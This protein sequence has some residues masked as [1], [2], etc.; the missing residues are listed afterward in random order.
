M[1]QVDV[2]RKSQQLKENGHN[3][4]QAAL[5]AFS[6]LIDIPESELFAISEGFGGGIGD[7]Q[8]ICGA[9]SGAVMALS[10]LRSGRDP[11]HLTKEKTYELVSILKERFHQKIGS[12][13]CKDI[14]GE[15]TGVELYSCGGCVEV[16]VEITDQLIKEMK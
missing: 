13:T 11:S 2:V 5:G 12:T 4:A 8:G 15:E 6:H 3:C 1:N 9:V 10:L 16:A 7:K 14:L